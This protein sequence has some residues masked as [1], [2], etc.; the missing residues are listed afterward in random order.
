MVL[1]VDR[2]GIVRYANQA[3]RRFIGHDPEELI[4]TSAIEVLHPDDR[5]AAVE[6][7]SRSST[8][9]FEDVHGLRVL[10]ADGTY[11]L[12]EIAAAN[13][14][15]DP[16]IQ[17]VVAGVRDVSNRP[18]ADQAVEVLRRRFEYAFDHSPFAHAVVDLDGRIVR[19]N[20]RMAELSGYEAETSSA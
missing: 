4:G 16:E 13:H 8:S 10:A 14:S 5:G 11:R 6:Q 3:V 17:G 15:D 12:V 9:A 7:L 18:D 2:M 20:R 1:V 19:I